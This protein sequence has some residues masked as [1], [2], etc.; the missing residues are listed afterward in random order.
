MRQSAD[1]LALPGAG[2][3]R[4]PHRA[5]CARWG[6]VEG[7]MRGPSTQDCEKSLARTGHESWNL[8]TKKAERTARPS[9][10]R[11]GAGTFIPLSTLRGNSRELTPQGVPR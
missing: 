5:V 2:L 9:A 10:S 1:L 11:Q 7:N 3:A 4:G 8:K 6:G